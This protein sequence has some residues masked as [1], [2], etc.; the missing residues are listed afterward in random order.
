MVIEL[1]NVFWKKLR[2]IKMTMIVQMMMKIPRYFIIAFENKELFVI[3]TYE[4]DM[5]NYADIAH[6]ICNIH[7]TET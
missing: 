3:D 7:H 6:M 4:F 5:R 1:R 2:L